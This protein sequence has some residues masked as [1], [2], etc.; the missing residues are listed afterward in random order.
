MSITDK[1]TLAVHTCWSATCWLSK[2]KCWCQTNLQVKIMQIFLQKIC[3]F[4][5]AYV[6]TILTKNFPPNADDTNGDS[7]QLPNET[8]N[9]EYAIISFVIM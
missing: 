6:L 3:D 8:R 5:S 2:Q 4:H 9:L 1:V 7:K